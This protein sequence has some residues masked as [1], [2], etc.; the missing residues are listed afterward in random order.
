MKCIYNKVI[1]AVKT[2]IVL[3]KLHYLVIF[4][5]SRNFGRL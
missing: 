3:Y 1:K 5:A 2:Y 4:T